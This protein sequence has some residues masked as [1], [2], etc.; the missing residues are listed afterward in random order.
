MPMSSAEKYCQSFGA[1]LVSLHDDDETFWV[2][3]MGGR[4]DSYWTGLR[5]INTSTGK[6]PS[7]GLVSHRLRPHVID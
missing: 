4:R 3:D 2:Y 5:Q 7:N 6:N 1:H